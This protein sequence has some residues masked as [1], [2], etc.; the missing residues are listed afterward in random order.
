VIVLLLWKT[1]RKFDSRNARCVDFIE[2]VNIA[3]GKSD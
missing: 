1:R 3:G 2:A